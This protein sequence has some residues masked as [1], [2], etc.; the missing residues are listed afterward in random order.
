MTPCELGWPSA[1]ANLLSIAAGRFSASNDTDSAM[2]FQYDVG[3][4]FQM[5]HADR[6][7]RPVTHNCVVQ[8][9]KPSHATVAAAD[10]LGRVFFLAPEPQSYGYERNMYTAAQ[11]HMGQCP[12]GIA[13][14]NL[15]QPSRHS[16]LEA[17]QTLQDSPTQSATLHSPSYKHRSGSAL[18][19]LAVPEPSGQQSPAAQL[20]QGAAILSQL[21]DDHS[22]DMRQQA[23]LT[24]PQSISRSPYTGH[25]SSALT[26]ALTASPT[27]HTQQ[28]RTQ[29]PSSGDGCSWVVVTTAGDVVQISSVSA[30]QYQ[31]LA[32]LQAV[33]AADA[34]TAP[35]SGCEL[36]QYRASLQ[37]IQ[38]GPH[39]QGKL[40]E[41]D[42]MF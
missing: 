31:L 9:P 11:Y 13:D 12:A 36:S 26:A 6:Y 41:T 10:R 32:A 30:D 18:P 33:M 35:L 4:G 22:Q 29:Q 34:I 17:V 39:M 3:S 7:S 25:L 21:H 42:R 14:A 5:L 1:V 2:L 40:I 23:S 27:S 20:H 24:H 19:P 8:Q 37:P 15:L 28:S 38:A 16:D